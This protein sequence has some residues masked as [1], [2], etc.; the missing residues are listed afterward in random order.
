MTSATASLTRG[1][2][3]V[4]L[5]MTYLGTD[6]W[7]ADLSAVPGPDDNGAEISG[8]TCGDTAPA[9]QPDPAH[10]VNMSVEVPPNPDGTLTTLHL[11]GKADPR[12]P[13]CPFNAPVA[14]FTWVHG[15]VANAAEQTFV[16]GYLL[17]QQP[18]AV[19]TA[20]TPAGDG[21]F[22]YDIS[23]DAYTAQSTSSVDGKTYTETWYG[24]CDFTQT[25]PYVGVAPLPLGTV[26]FGV[27]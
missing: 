20:M 23:A 1:G 24:S 9:A 18:G 12:I 19:S 27:G 14:S 3:T 5:P 6:V 15:F 8:G 26:P 22:F 2:R 13:A 7:Y 21:T 16:G 10:Q 17:A 25:P 4:Q 11:V